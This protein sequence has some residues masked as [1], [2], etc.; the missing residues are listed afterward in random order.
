MGIAISPVNPD[1]LYLI[2]EAQ[3]ESGGFYRSVNRGAS[4][5]RMNSYH[6]SGQYYNK[7]ICDPKDVDR[8]F[9][10]DTYTQVTVDGGRTWSGSATTASC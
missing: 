10:L 3:G 7:I 8:V 4:W 5:E 6:S 1:V 2:V 9:S